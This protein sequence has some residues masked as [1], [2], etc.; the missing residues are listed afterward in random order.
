M[1]ELYHTIYIQKN[2]DPDTILAVFILREFGDL[3]YPGITQAN[4][5]LLDKM[6]VSGLYCR[7]SYDC[8]Q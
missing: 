5:H 7:V 1:A 3:K 8:R 6:P 4:I 2:I